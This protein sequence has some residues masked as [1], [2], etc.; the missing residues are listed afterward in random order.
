M[1]SALRRSPVWWGCDL[2]CPWFDGGGEV[3]ECPLTVPP[4]PPA[5][6]QPL[7]AQGQVHQ[8]A[9]LLPVP[10]PAGLHRPALRDRR[11]RVRLQPVSERRHLPG[12]DRGVPVHLHARCEGQPGKLGLLREARHRCRESGGG[13]ADPGRPAGCGPG[14]EVAGCRFLG[15]DRPGPCPCPH[16][17]LRGCILRGEQGRVCQQPLP[18]EWPVPG[19][20]QRVPVRVSPRCGAGLILWEPQGSPGVAKPRAQ[21]LSFLL[22]GLPEER[23]C[24]PDP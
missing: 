22:L 15:P 8:H 13:R 18:A 11:Q 16:P 24:S 6:C 4:P 17:R 7:R 2:T 3:P 20:D 19:Q 10:V 14:V 23:A 1:E 21:R 9:G 12:P 5:R